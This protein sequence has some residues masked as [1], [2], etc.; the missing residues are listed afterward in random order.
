MAKMGSYEFPEIGLNE[1]VELARRIRDELGG[2]VSRDGLATVLAMSPH[3]GAYGARI[4]ALRIWGLAVGRRAI[5][6]TPVAD[7]AIAASGTADE[8]VAMRKIVRSVPL[9]SE[10]EQRVGAAR[11]E[12]TVL[13]VMLQEITGVG[14]DD[15]QRRLPTVE[16]VF[17]GVQR[18]FAVKNPEPAD[19]EVG[20]DFDVGTSVEP[21]SPN[22][23]PRGWMEFRYDDG[24]L[25]MRE[26]A[27]NLEVLR[28]VLE[29]RKQRLCDAD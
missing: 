15:V 17:G 18:H 24:T 22:A 7:D 20:D 11:T 29:S 28:A 19:P 10:L 13:A 14:M 5:A 9:F 21:R 16:R 2:E 1:S 25:R 26:T 8:D 12:S 4:G 6:T 3:G 23:L 27:E